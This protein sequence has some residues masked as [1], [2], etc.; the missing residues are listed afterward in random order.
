VQDGKVRR[1]RPGG[2]SEP[3]AGSTRAGFAV[4]PALKISRPKSR[5]PLPEIIEEFPSDPAKREQREALSSPGEAAFWPDLPAS[6]EREDLDDARMLCREL[7]RQA[8]LED[9]QR[10]IPWSA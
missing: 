9:E 5:R 10:G 4:I 6:A 1:P 3:P 8:L 7:R 2:G